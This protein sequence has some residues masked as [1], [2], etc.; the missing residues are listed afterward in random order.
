MSFGIANLYPQEPEKDWL[1]DRGYLRGPQNSAHRRVLRS[2]HPR[3]CR[4]RLFPWRPVENFLVPHPTCLRAVMRQSF[5][6]RACLIFGTRTIYKRTEGLT[7]ASLLFA[8][9]SVL[10]ETHSSTQLIEICP[11]RLS[12]HQKDR[13]PRTDRDMHS[14]IFLIDFENRA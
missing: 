5:R 2:C 1:Q 14:G 11:M 13:I 3:T 4:E 10:T 9:A 12:P 6:R 7:L 8:R